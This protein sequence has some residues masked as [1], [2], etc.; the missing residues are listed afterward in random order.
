MGRSYG[1]NSAG[2]IPYRLKFGRKVVDV[3]D[4]MVKMF[5]DVFIEAGQDMVQGDLGRVL[6]FHPQLDNHILV[7]MRLWHEINPNVIRQAIKNVLNSN[8]GLTVNAEKH[9]Y[10]AQDKLTN[11]ILEKA[12]LTDTAHF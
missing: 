7:R 12:C 11:L 9:S 4:E 6:I 2:D 5:E 10:K 1:N 8:Q 3:L